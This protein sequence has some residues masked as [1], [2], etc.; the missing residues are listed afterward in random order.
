[1]TEEEK[2]G[3]ESKATDAFR[4]LG[5]LRDLGILKWIPHLYESDK[6]EAE[7]IHSVGCGQGEDIENKLGTKAQEAAVR[8]VTP[9]QLDWARE[10]LDCEPILLPVLRHM[11]EVVL[12]GIARLHYRPRTKMT[13]AW[14][15]KA[16]ESMM[17]WGAIYDRLRQ[18]ATSRLYQ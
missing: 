17:H 6:P 9:G 7:I 1:M 16:N 8:M 4:R 15:A 11:T 14:W 13:A 5:Q 18:N 3:G 2:A 12:I 10:E